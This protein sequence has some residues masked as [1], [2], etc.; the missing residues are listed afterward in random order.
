VE[1]GCTAPVSPALPSVDVGID[2][3]SHALLTERFRDPV[4]N[5]LDTRA[6]TV[7]TT[8]RELVHRHA[9][10]SATTRVLLALLATAVL[11]PFAG[12][13]LVGLAYGIRIPVSFA[14][15]AAGG[16]GVYVAYLLARGVADQ[17]EAAP[18]DANPVRRARRAALDATGSGPGAESEPESDPDPVALLQERYA[19]GEVGDEEFERRM[20]RLL[21]SDERRSRPL[22]RSRSRSGSPSTSGSGSVSSQGPGTVG[23]DPTARRRDDVDADAERADTALD[24]SG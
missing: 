7:W 4:P 9:P 5:L 8:M 18:T 17:A 12:W 2:P 20:D 22:S 1:C 19:R 13:G 14:L 24:R 16:A 23:A 6:T 10:D 15:F 11:A 21:E 3:S